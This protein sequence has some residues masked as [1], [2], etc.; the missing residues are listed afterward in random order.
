MTQ[1][2]KK[3]CF[4]KTDEPVSPECLGLHASSGRGDALGN[5]NRNHK[6]EF[7]TDIQLNNHLI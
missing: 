6:T 2:P 5:T 7:L 3:P 1:S 4:L